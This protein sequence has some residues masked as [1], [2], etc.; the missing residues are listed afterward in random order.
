MEPTESKK[1]DGLCEL[2][3]KTQ[4]WPGLGINCFFELIFVMY[5]I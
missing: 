2:T 3:A 5:V 1:M 4:F